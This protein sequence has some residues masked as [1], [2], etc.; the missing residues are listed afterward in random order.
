MLGLV[1]ALICVSRPARVLCPGSAPLH[2]SGH[3]I[4]RRSHIVMFLGLGHKTELWDGQL[5]ASALDVASTLDVGRV[6]GSWVEPPWKATQYGINV[7]FTWPYIPER[8]P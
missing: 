7:A 8:S 1:W 3:E 5:F 2:S 6:M 4:A